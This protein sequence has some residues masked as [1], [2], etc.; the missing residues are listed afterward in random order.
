MLK[1][2]LVK[3]FNG[4]L[5]PAT[6]LAEATLRRR[7]G[8]PPDA[9]ARMTPT[10]LAWDA[11]LGRR[12]GAARRDFSTLKAP[13]LA[14]LVSI[15]LPVHNGERYLA[16]A[17]DSI[18]GQTYRDFELILVDDGST[19]RTPELIAAYAARD[20]RIRPVRQRNARLPGAL[21]AGFRLARGEFLTWTSDDNR[22]RPDFLAQMVAAL[23]A[24]PAADMLF[25]DYDLIGEDGARLQDSPVCARLQDPPGSGH[26]HLLRDISILNLINGNYIGGAFLYRARALR[27]IG[28]YSPRRFTCEDYDYWLRVN[29]QLRLRHAPFS[30]IVYEYRIHGASLTAQKDALAIDRRTEELMA[31]DDF[32]RDFASHPVA[33]MLDLALETP[34]QGE[35]PQTD[36][37]VLDLAQQLDARIRRAGHLLL[38]P[39]QFPAEAL[40][41]AGFPS[42]HLTLA[43]DLSPETLRIHAAKPLPPGALRIL[44]Y[45]G[46]GPLPEAVAPEWDLCIAW[47][48]RLEPTPLPQ[49]R[50]G[51]L[52]AGDLA[53]LWNALLVRIQSDQASRL[54]A[55]A[56][57]AAEGPAPLKASVVICTRRRPR[58]LEAAIR[59]ALRQTV[60]P[61]DYEVLVVNN[62]PA[63]DDLS[64]LIERLRRER[65]DG[66]APALR[67][68]LA[69]LRGLS[70]ARN[71]GLAAA[72]GEIV[73]YLD[74]DALAEPNWLER[75]LAAYARHPE[76]AAI[77]GAILL[78]D[79]PRP[80]WLTPAARKYWSHFEPANKAFHLSGDWRQ[81]PWG[82]NWSAR[83]AALL[84]IGGFRHRYG[85]GG[86]HRTGE[87]V[88]AALLLQRLGYAI[89][90]EP[91]ARVVH[92]VDPA[93][94]TPGE[95]ARTIFGGFDL[96]IPLELDF[97]MEREAHW[98]RLLWQALG[99]LRHAAYAARKD[100]FEAIASALFA[101]A[102]A[103]LA[104]RQIALELHRWRI[105]RQDK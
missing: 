43:N 82:A 79:A 102:H 83:R 85:R 12:D 86:A 62:D 6:R 54:E 89:G 4:A 69:P 98:P 38:R 81:F 15:V 57:R 71:A 35:A 96:R 8:L 70:I 52:V 76:C 75:L 39:G 20:G 99:H 42:A 23:Q 91:A 24:D 11:W 95:L 72:R 28:D 105:P 64:G 97:Y 29:E 34:A 55:E 58:T 9:P 18:L 68:V 78:K 33:W 88:V 49:P 51:W 10:Q 87:E 27:L 61:S 30:D 48:G 63:H 3:L 90:V 104:L 66:P 19:D 37:Q 56:A 46:A 40:P 17:L 5:E 84:A 77:G 94:F 16:E 59:A 101:A 65:G 92:D 73:A 80:A 13:G 41:P 1:P 36:R 25:A 103:R 53:T 60:P 100:R 26:V 45:A 32:R 74:D 7:R 21:N 67:Q 50:Q 31:F 44:V 14:G 22:L 47:G 93:R 2:L